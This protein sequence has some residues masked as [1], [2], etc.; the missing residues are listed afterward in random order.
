[1]KQNVIMIVHTK[2][3]EQMEVTIRDKRII[4]EN[5]LQELMDT[6]GWSSKMLADKVGVDYSYMYRI[7]HN[8][9]DCGRKFLLGLMKLC[10]EEKLNIYDFININ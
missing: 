10:I 3:G 5:K 4:R 1:M 7:M 8:S 9:R 6:R 2:G